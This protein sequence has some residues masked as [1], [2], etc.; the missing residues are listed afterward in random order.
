MSKMSF[1]PSYTVSGCEDEAYNDTFDYR[2]TTENGALWWRSRR[3]NKMLR[4][5]PGWGWSLG[6]YT[7]S[8]K[9]DVAPT[10]GWTFN[11]GQCDPPDLGKHITITRV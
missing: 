6:W 7:H 1:F 3:S 9:S 4:H 11:G 5:T 2:E 8:S 10:N